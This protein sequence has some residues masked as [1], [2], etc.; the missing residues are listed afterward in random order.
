MT[1]IAK[2]EAPH[3]VLRDGYRF[4]R[5]AR[6]EYLDLLRAGYGRAAAAQRVN[7]SQRQIRKTIQLNPEFA[8]AVRDAEGQADDVVQN[9]LYQ[10]AVGHQAVDREGNVYDVPGSVEA[11]KFWLANRRTAEWNVGVARTPV[12]LGVADDI[13]EIQSLDDLRETG[14]AVIRQLLDKVQQLEAAK[15]ETFDDD[16]IE[17]ESEEILSSIPPVPGTVNDPW[18]E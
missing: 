16:I 17:A 11:Q 18:D 14:R 7:I 9:S 10:K 8:E 13:E 3:V 12:T 4:D 5:Y 15:A 2:Y 6:Q 1:D